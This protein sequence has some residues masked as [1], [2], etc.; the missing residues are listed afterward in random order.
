MIRVVRDESSPGRGLPGEGEGG[1]SRRTGVPGEGC[2]SWGGGGRGLP[3]EGAV[4][5]SRGGGGKRLP[6]EGAGVCI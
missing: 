1:A 3:R 2:A 5:A 6:G 4:G